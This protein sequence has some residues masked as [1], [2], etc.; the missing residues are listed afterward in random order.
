MAKGFAQLDRDIWASMKSWPGYAHCG[1]FIWGLAHEPIHYA[2]GITQGY[3][4]KLAALDT[5]LPIK[6]VMKARRWL[7]KKKLWM[8][9]DGWLWVVKAARR[10]LFNN[11]LS[12]NQKLT[13]AANNYFRDESVPEGITAA[14][15]A[16]YGLPAD[17]VSDRVSLPYVREIG[18]TLSV[19]G[20]GKGDVHPPKPPL[21]AGGGSPGGCGEREQERKRAARAER[22]ASGQPPA[23][24]SKTPSTGQ[25]TAAMA[26]AQVESKAAFEQAQRLMTMGDL[27][28]EREYEDLLTACNEWKTRMSEGHSIELVKKWNARDRSR[29]VERR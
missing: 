29:D 15:K 9:E 11:D 28:D 26:W 24:K 1:L 12:R 25:V 8:V 23:G 6:D 13:A 27:R 18:A 16:M 2:T 10:T 22:P 7:V 17:R 5:H 14:F 19:N 3:S 21:P 4:D 20:T